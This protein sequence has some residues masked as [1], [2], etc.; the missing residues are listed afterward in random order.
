MEIRL[1]PA[2]IY[3][4]QLDHITQVSLVRQGLGC[5]GPAFSL[6]SGRLPDLDQFQA[7][8]PVAVWI[9][10]SHLDSCACLE[11]EYQTQAQAGYVFHCISPALGGCG[12]CCG[13]QA[14][15]RYNLPQ[16]IDEF[17]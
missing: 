4:L 1:T 16:K 7:C 14:V 8:G 12:S 13:C 10:A 17:V 5:S 2:A 15:D 9:Q 3:Q 11:I 6:V